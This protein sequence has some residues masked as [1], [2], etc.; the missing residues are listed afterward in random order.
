MSTNYFLRTDHKDWHIGKSSVGW[1]F[2]LHIYPDEN[3]CELSDWSALFDEGSIM[4]E[5]GNFIS[6]DEMLSI[7]FN[8]HKKDGF[9]PAP[10]CEPDCVYGIHGLKRIA[11]QKEGAF[12]AYSLE[13]K[14]FC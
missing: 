10:A 7:I 14:E 4:D 9:H 2:I 6:K 13:S 1:Y 5:Y 3:I 8:H 11:Y 12:G